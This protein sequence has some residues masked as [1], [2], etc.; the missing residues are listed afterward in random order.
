MRKSAL[1]LFE[2][3]TVTS[4]LEAV[5]MWT[6]YAKAAAWL[7]DWVYGG[8]EQSRTRAVAKSSMKIGK[9][10]QPVTPVS[11]AARTLI[12]QRQKE[13]IINFAKEI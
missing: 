6:R 8:V 3:V 13:N 12:T 1:S 2:Q 7:L 9:C 10:G 5:T 4:A 11:N